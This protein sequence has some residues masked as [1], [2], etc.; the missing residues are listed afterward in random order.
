MHL[1]AAVA[2][3][4]LHLQSGRYVLPMAAG[5]SLN[6]Q[7][8]LINSTQQVQRLFKPNDMD[9]NDTRKLFVAGLSDTVTE[10]V[11]RQLFESAGGTILECAV[12]KDRQ[13]GRG[14]GFGFVTLSSEDEANKVRGELDGSLQE[15]RPI[16]VRAFRGNRQD[17]RGPRPSGPPGA[18]ASGYSGPPPS[19]DRED[20]ENTLFM[21]GLPG[22][23]TDAEIN[24]VF[25]QAGVGPILKLHL[26]VDPD[27]RRRGFG[28]VSLQDAAAAREAVPKLR[29]CA[30]RGRPLTVDVARPRGE[31]PDRGGPPER[32]GDRSSGWSGKPPAP[33]AGGFS[34]GSPPAR[35]FDSGGG[36]PSERQTWDERRGGPGGGGRRPT[37]GGG[38][39]KKK[40][41]RGGGGDRSHSRRDS[42]GF[43]A[44]RSRGY[45]DWDDD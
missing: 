9:D 44:P 20:R 35:S 19:R 26:P 3:A 13:T 23:C 32:G 8:V 38:S 40:K 24:E 7:R 30:L 22:D 39:G 12:P 21:A 41:E 31:R 28:F 10:G 25:E 45:T 29:D 6:P 42:E 14:R 34:G 5:G 36:A 37:S 17:T 11:L 1:D 43:R 4:T 27:G 2:I 33:R 18:G 16:S 15:G